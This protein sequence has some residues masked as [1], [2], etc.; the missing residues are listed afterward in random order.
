MC[1]CMYVCVR[2]YVY[3]CVCM[4]S[5]QSLAM[6]VGPIYEG[7]SNEN[8]KYFLSRSSLNTKSTQ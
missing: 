7:E 4:C 8:R 5:V 6:R 3:V 2:M 1:E